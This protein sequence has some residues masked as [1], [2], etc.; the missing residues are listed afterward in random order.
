[1]KIKSSSQVLA[2]WGT[3]GSTLLSV[4]KV[5]GIFFVAVITLAYSKL[6]KKTL[7]GSVSSIFSAVEKDIFLVFGPGE[8]IKLPPSMENRF[9]AQAWLYCIYL[10]CWSVLSLGGDSVYILSW[11]NF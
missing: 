7:P 11:E 4:R 3:I 10:G 6:L 9:S 2:V 1:M 5:I 8:G